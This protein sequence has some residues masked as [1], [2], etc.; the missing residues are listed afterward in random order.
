MFRLHAQH[1]H[2]HT[3]IWIRCSYLQ[4]C[5][6]SFRL[7]V[8]TKRKTANNARCLRIEKL[9]HRSVHWTILYL[10]PHLA[11]L[12]KLIGLRHVSNK[13]KWPTGHRKWF[14][15][16]SKYFKTNLHLN[17]T[18]FGDRTCNLNRM[19]TMWKYVE[20]VIPCHDLSN[21]IRQFNCLVTECG[22]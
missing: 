10:S 4:H 21:A 13:W 7:R 14:S 12:M 22:N 3:I 2:R 1:R 18:K 6:A 9:P 17:C 19:C 11:Y 5:S 16:T 20:T 8:Y 15:M